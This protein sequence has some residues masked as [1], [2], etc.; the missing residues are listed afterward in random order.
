MLAKNKLRIALIGNPNSGKTTLFNALTGSNQHVGNWPGVT[1][2]KKSGIMKHKDYELEIIDLPGIYSLNA[3]SLDE[4]IA[5]NF[6]VNEQPDLILN[7][8]DAGNME[9]N[10]YL[11]MQLL[12][13]RKPVLIALNMID[14]LEKMDMIVDYPKMETMLNCPIMPISATKKEGLE[15]LKNKLI[16]VDSFQEYISTAKV[17]YDEVI[18]ASIDR[19]ENFL[20]AEAGEDINQYL[21]TKQVDS[22]QIDDP[23]I[24]YGTIDKHYFF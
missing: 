17:A 9:R 6:I 23:C 22:C 3:Q 8:V 4:K 14:L 16:S 18:F 12:Q 5:R 20:E 10:L 19:I 21:Y 11:T 2:E 7:I 24:Y 15:E 13:Y 1:V